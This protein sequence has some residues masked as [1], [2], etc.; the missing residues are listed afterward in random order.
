MTYFSCGENYGWDFAAM[1]GKATN[2]GKKFPHESQKPHSR[3]PMNGLAG[4]VKNNFP[5][6]GEP[7]MGNFFFTMTAK[8]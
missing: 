2:A 4:I 7:R 6:S 8:P 3:F 5:M 1:S